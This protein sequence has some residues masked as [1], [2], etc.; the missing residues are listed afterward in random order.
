[1][2]VING[3]LIILLA[4]MLW[5]HWF[6][7]GGVNELKEKQLL[8]NNQLK[9]NKLLKERNDKLVA[10]VE[11]LKHGLQAIE[12]R[13]RSEMGMVKPDEIFIQVIEDNQSQ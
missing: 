2:K 11:D 6:G 13:A 12:E 8:Y 7:T 1:M 5:V 9:K 4:T 10:E 3:I